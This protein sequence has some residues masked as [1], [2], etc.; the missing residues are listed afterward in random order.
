MYF[1]PGFIPYVKR[2][3]SLF[4]LFAVFNSTL[5]HLPLKQITKSKYNHKPTYETLRQSLEAM[6]A[7]CLENG[8]TSLSIPRYGA[9]FAFHRLT[10]TLCI[11]LNNLNIR[12]FFYPLLFNFSVVPI[13]YL[14]GIKT[15]S[16]SI[17]YIFEYI[18]GYFRIGC[19][20]DKLKWEKVSVIIE[21]VFQHTDV[22]ITVY[23]L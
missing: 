20:L 2:L 19:G 22:V 1:S 17:Y 3:I 10:L 21:E 14:E 13:I 23:S 8:V 4:V 6:K 18:F 12:S 7:H 16:F 11:S 5:Y 9:F 15:V